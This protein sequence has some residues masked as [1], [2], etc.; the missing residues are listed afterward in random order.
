MQHTEVALVPCTSYDPVLLDAALQQAAE[1]AGFPDVR[2]RKVL[3]KPN[4]LNASPSAKAVTT[5]PAFV[6]AVIRLLRARG[7]TEILVGDSPGWQPGQ[8]AARASGIFQAVEAEG[9]RWVDFKEVTAHAVSQSKVLRNIPLTSW[10]DE[11][12][13]VVNLPK[14]KTHR[15]MTY[16]GAMK[17]LFGLIPGT[18]KSAMHMQYPLARDFGEV[19]VD[20]ALSIQPSFTFMDAIVAMQGEGPGNGTPYALGVILAS[21]SMPDL[22][23]VAARC[24][25]Y[26]PARIHYLAD[27]ME[28]VHHGIS[29]YEPSTAP[30]SPGEVRHEGFQL[31]PYESD[32]SRRLGGMP[33]RI[34]Q[35]VLKVLQRRPVFR[36]AR[37]IGCQACIRIC[38]AKVLSLDTHMGSNTVRIDDSHCI[39]CFCCHEVCPANAIEIGRV[40]TRIWHR[41]QSKI[42]SKT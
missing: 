40:L 20:L 27:A 39:T 7:C 17:N 26:D 31:L 24:I 30:L 3:I 28:R 37:C 42:S 5:H 6:A 11:V 23:W 25:G 2:N 12:D 13:V 1:I 32:L 19:L 33:S 15:L 35:T 36:T 34:R 41:P 14:L 38:P 22:D 16:T 29:G 4:V 18:A 21:R 10:L 8:L 9:A